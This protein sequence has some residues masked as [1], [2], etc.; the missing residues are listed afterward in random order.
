MHVSECP[1]DDSHAT[2]CWSFWHFSLDGKLSDDKQV[3]Y[4]LVCLQTSVAK[5]CIVGTKTTTTLTT[6]VQTDYLKYLK[7]N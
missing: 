6:I 7:F 5:S 1:W 3:K 4:W 2:F